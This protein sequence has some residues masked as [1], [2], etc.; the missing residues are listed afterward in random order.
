[1]PTTLTDSSARFELQP[2][3]AGA[4]VLALTGRLDA[5]SV[6]GLWKELEARLRQAPVSML[7]VD[8]AS[9][10][11]CDGAGLALLHFLSMGGMSPSG[12]KATVRGLRPEF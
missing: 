3:S 9:V 10:D 1:M 2:G 5:R 12:V 8:A 4:S 7:E 6:A 11:Y